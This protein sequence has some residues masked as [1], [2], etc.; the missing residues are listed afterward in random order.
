MSRFTSRRPVVLIAIGAVAVGEA[1]VAWMFFFSWMQNFD[2]EGYMVTMYRSWIAGGALYDDVYSQYGPFH[3]VAVGLPFR[4]VN[5]SMTLTTGR[6][7]TLALFVTTTVLLAV[8]AYVLTRSLVSAVLAQLLSFWSIYLV[9]SAP[10]HPVPLLIFL[11]AAL[12]A[13]V[14]AL[15]PRRPVLSDWITGGI[16]AAALLT[17]IN[18]GLF[19]AVA[20]AYV[21][22]IRFPVEQARRW[23]LP[24][25]EVM[26][27]AIG[28]LLLVSQRSSISRAH[29]GVF[30]GRDPHVVDYWTLAYVAAAV[31]V[32][33]FG[34]MGRARQPEELTVFSLGALSGGFGVVALFSIGTALLTGT[35]I[36]ALV[37]GVL[38]RPLG[39]SDAL[40][41]LPD[42]SGRMLVLL[43]ATPVLIW[44]GWLIGRA[45][46]EPRWYLGSGALRTIGGGSL[47]VA[48]C[49]PVAT[50]LHLKVFA[51]SFAYV[52]LTALILLPSLNERPTSMTRR[53]FVA[54]LAVAHTLHAFPVAGLQAYASMLFPLFCGVVIV[55]DGVREFLA[56]A[57]ETTH[58]IRWRAMTSGVVVTAVLWLGWHIGDTA[59]DWIDEYRTAEPLDLPN[60]TWMRGRADLVAQ[61]RDLVAQVDDCKQLVSYPGANSLNLWTEIPPA[62]GYNATLWPALLTD[63][64]QRAIVDQLKATEDPV[65]LVV[66]PA[67]TSALDPRG[68]PLERYLADFD[69]RGAVYGYRILTRPAP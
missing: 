25:T 47:V 61:L 55:D 38:I 17:K 40:T 7:I 45:D 16:V 14:V 56:A 41:V 57:M 43:I 10:M 24:V 6:C 42:M 27:V 5:A 26:L 67:P 53:S 9:V 48:A 52:P 3:A 68:G 69:P 49:A 4:L 51:G 18:V 20:V 58:E 32:V 65:C 8:A 29:L 23:L 50:A 31:T 21:V 54:A 11:I 34:R 35:S 63:G 15:R 62:N 28:P 36:G 30:S 44:I 13:N 46:P 66:R 22:A 2:D 60:S 39:Q 12:V 59:K 19:V 37:R 64:E 33:V 1:I